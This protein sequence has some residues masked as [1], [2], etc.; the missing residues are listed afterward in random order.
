MRPYLTA[1]SPEDA[2]R[3]RAAGH[4]RSETLLDLVH[5][6]AEEA[7]G[8]LALAD[9]LVTLDNA[10]LRRGVGGVASM[11]AE[12][13]VRSG[14]PVLVQLRNGSPHALANLAL[15][16]L[17]AVIVPIKTSLRAG[18]VE[19][20][21]ARVGAAKA[22]V[23]PDGE[24][25]VPGAV[26]GLAAI[27]EAA[28]VDAATRAE[29]AEAPRHR[30]GGHPDAVLDLMFTSGTTGVPKGILNSTNT[31]LSALR[32]LVAE[33]GLGP[34]DAWLV[35][36]PMAH[37][38]G[39]L[40][41][42]LPALLTGAPAVFQR[43]YQPD[44]LLERIVRHSVRAVFLTPTH[45]SDVLAALAGGA[46]PPEDLRFVLIGGAATSPEVKA[47][48]RSGLDVE[49]I[50]I[51]G[52]TE[53]QG[54]T[55]V[56]PGTEPELGDL[57]VGSPCPGNEV[58]IFDEQRR[59]QLPSGEVG[60]IGTRGA[61]TF[62][63][64]FDDQA[65]TD[66]AFN[67]EG[68]FFSGDLGLLDERGALHVV[69][70]SKELIIRGGLN[71]VP[72][73]VEE[74]LSAHPAV[75]EVAAVGLPDER[76]GERVCAVVVLEPGEELDLAEAVAHLESSGVGTHLWPEALLVVAHLP[77]TDLGKVQRSALREA[78]IEAA[79]AGGRDP[80]SDATDA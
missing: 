26:A 49:V 59:E 23:D 20:V 8:R 55:F 11:L 16:A 29:G 42:F 7:P 32:G 33:L 64:Y 50:S 22:V 45:A 5:R 27:T 70:R 79:Q 40:Y 36:P 18:E 13:G 72:D 51:Y 31:K 34:D 28:I 2:E 76:L 9:E 25:A 6:R 24:V 62:L 15:S 17:G 4:W 66:A 41:S 69:G 46:A 37:N 48:L 77:R 1:F 65:A 78:A 44:E 30:S 10:G 52:C 53:N 71:I 73:D 80:V 75:A 35:V 54:V 74:A 56:R 47:G 12:L 3:H 57:T 21:A 14:D 60:E 39:W 58:A 63:G 19:T 67:R 43:R 38:A 61:G 68:W